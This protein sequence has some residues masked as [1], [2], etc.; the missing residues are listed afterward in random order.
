MFFISIYWPYW[1]FFLRW[2]SMWSH[3]STISFWQSWKITC[4]FSCIVLLNPTLHCCSLCKQNRTHLHRLFLPWN[5]SC[6]PP[7]CW[8]RSFYWAHTRKVLSP[9]WSICNL[10]VCKCITRNYLISCLH[11][12]KHFSDNLFWI[13][14]QRADF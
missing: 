11:I 5:D 9:S 14:P 1:I 12:K 7:D 3:T 4:F 2:V 10:W 8:I 6:W 13:L